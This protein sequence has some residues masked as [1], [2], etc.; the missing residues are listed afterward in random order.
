[1]FTSQ[2]PLKSRLLAAGVHFGISVAIAALAAWL[3]FAVWYPY[4]YREISGGRELFLIV[5]TVDVILGP[6]LTLAV[7]DTKKSVKT[8]R[9]DLTVIGLFQLAA[10][11]YGLWT[12]VV[13]RPVYLAFEMDRFRVIHAIEVPEDELKQAPPEFQRLPLTGPTL[14]SLRDFKDNKERFEATMTALQGVPL[15]ARPGLWQTYAQGKSQVLAHARPLEELK[16]RFPARVAEIDSALKSAS[17]GSDTMR[18]TGYIPMIG[19]KTFWTVLVD[20]RTA[21]VIAFVPI[22]SF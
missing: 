19:R 9:L 16:T 6:L 1:M 3:V 7:F 11:A 10:L 12:V 20:S 18:P 21:E 2:S 17:G 13:V 4:P 5:V 22:D 8:L 14:L 15:G